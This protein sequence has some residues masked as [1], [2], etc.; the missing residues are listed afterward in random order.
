MCE[1]GGNFRLQ[2][3]LNLLC[4][5]EPCVP[6][7][8]KT[9]SGLNLKPHTIFKICNQFSE[10]VFFLEICKNCVSSAVSTFLVFF[11]LVDHTVHIY[12]I[13]WLKI[14]LKTVS[15]KKCV[16]MFLKKWRLYWICLVLPEFC[17]SVIPEFCHNSDETWISLRPVGQY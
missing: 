4:R 1:M 14:W 3:R 16:F 13:R 12:T 17:G 5:V 15:P 8:K 11:S 10:R 9:H 2:N 6:C 7:P